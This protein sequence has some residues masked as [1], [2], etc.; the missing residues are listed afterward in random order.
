M[1]STFIEFGS[2]FVN[3]DLLKLTLENETV[4]LEILE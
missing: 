3:S 1:A 2:C 4:I